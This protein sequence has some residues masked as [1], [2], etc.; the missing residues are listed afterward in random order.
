MEFV[1]WKYRSFNGL[2]QLATE[3]PL[4]GTIDASGVFVWDALEGFHDQVDSELGLDC[5]F[6]Y[7]E[8]RRRGRS[9][10]ME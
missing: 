6:L 3:S 7:H 5:R 4:R 1:F 9:H 8:R 10:R 2:V